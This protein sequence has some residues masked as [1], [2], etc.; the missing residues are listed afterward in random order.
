MQEVCRNLPNDSQLIRDKI[1][2]IFTMRKQYC[3]KVVQR[4]FLANPFTPACRK[5]RSK[6]KAYEEDNISSNE[7]VSRR[8][9]STTISTSKESLRRMDRSD[10][11]IFKARDLNEK[12][13]RLKRLVGKAE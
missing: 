1:T 5:L 13:D 10:Q 2:N 3:L 12:I 8:P 7:A 9:F 6:S 4:R 11:L